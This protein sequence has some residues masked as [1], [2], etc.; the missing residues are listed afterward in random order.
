LGFPFLNL[1]KTVFFF[2]TAIII[3]LPVPELPKRSYDLTAL[4]SDESTVGQLTP[5]SLSPT[6]HDQRATSSTPRGFNK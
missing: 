1:L 6:A 2:I 5:V 4:T 3:E